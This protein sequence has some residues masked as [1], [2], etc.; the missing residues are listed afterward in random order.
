MG[1]DWENYHVLILLDFCHIRSMLVVEETTSSLWHVEQGKHVQQ[2]G[3]I[4][5]CHL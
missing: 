5:Q 4:H 1:K 3:K 2:L